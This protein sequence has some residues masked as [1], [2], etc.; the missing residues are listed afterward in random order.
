MADDL[1]SGSY[2]VALYHVPPLKDF[3]DVLTMIV[4]VTR[5]MIGGHSFL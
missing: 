4:G 1:V 2:V 5:I 3:F